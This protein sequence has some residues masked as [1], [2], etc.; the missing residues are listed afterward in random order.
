MSKKKQCRIGGE[1]KGR[2]AARKAW[3]KARKA[4]ARCRG[5]DSVSNPVG[6]LP[7]PPTPG[8]QQAADCMDEWMDAYNDA[9]DLDY[10]RKVI[11]AVKLQYAAAMKLP[12]GPAKTQLLKDIAK[13]IAEQEA[14]ARMLEVALAAQTQAYNECME[15]FL[16]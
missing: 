10:V 16:V 15:G 4:N 13:F 6:S 3:D 12:E 9:K 1:S 2:K 14:R 7:A 5:I 8:S 11:A